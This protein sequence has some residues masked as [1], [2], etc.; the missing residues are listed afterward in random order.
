MEPNR[1]RTGSL[2]FDPDRHLRWRWN[3]FLFPA[4][5]KRRSALLGADDL[6]RRRGNHGSR[7]YPVFQRTGLPLSPTRYRPGARWSFPSP[8]PCRK[9]IMRFMAILVAL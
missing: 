2:L 5:S 1:Q 9:V 4:L 7:R 8:R 3:D 6:G